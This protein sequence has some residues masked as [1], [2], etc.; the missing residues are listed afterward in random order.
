[1]LKTCLFLVFES[2]IIA[3]LIAFAGSGDSQAVAS[4]LLP[5]APTRWS[6]TYPADGT[7]AYGPVSHI[8]QGPPNKL[9][10]VFMYYYNN[11]IPGG[12]YGSELT[13]ERTAAVNTYNS[14]VWTVSPFG[15]I[16]EF[17]SAVVGDIAL[18][19]SQNPFGG[20]GSQQDVDSLVMGMGGDGAAYFISEEL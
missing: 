19:G 14:T 13:L 8:G 17:Y 20:S 7:I 11:T 6:I 9:G 3:A 15:D 12:V 18:Q 5:L 1:M 10:H 2:A 16:G 4:P